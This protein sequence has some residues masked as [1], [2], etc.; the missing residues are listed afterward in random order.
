MELAR[1]HGVRRKLARRPG[2]GPIPTL[3]WT[4]S[5]TKVWQAGRSIDLSRKTAPAISQ[6]F[7]PTLA[8][9]MAYAAS[10]AAENE[11]DGSSGAVLVSLFRDL[12][13]DRAPDADLIALADRCIAANE[14]FGVAA[15]AYARA[16][17]T[18]PHNETRSRSRSNGRA[19]RPPGTRLAIWNACSRTAGGRKSSIKK[20]LEIPSHQPWVPHSP[21]GGRSGLS[22][23]PAAWRDRARRCAV[24]ARVTAT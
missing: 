13:A 21:A 3:A 12:G 7:P 17:F 9:A 6:I 20:F 19:R 1:R 18:S 10:F 24:R 23:H 14:R 22:G 4:T 2:R 16:E 5:P 11:G 8:S 15:D